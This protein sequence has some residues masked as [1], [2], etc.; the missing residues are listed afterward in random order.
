MAITRRK[1]FGPDQVVDLDKYKDRWTN[2]EIQ[3]H[4]KRGKFITYKF[5]DLTKYGGDIYHSDFDNIGIRYDGNRDNAH[6][7][8][9]KSYKRVGW[10]YS[11]FPPIV[12][13][14]DNIKDGRTRIKAAINAGET[15]IAVAVFDYPEENDEVTAYIHQLSEGLIG[16]DDLYTRPTNYKGIF[17]SGL[18]AVKKA[19]NSGI[20]MHNRTE[21]AKLVIEEFEAERFL[22]SEEI[23]QVIDDI[24]EAISNGQEAIWLPT[25]EEVLDYIGKSP[26][27]PQDACLEGDICLNGKRVFVYAAPSNTNQGRL[28]AKIAD[29]I[30]EECYIVLYTTK[31]IPSKIKKGYDD[32][33]QYVDYRY[34]ECFEIVNRTC[35]QNGSM[36]KIQAP[37]TRPWKVIGVIPQLAQDET[38][39]S[40]K[41]SFELIPLEEYC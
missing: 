19:E 27:L 32:F 11:S 16:N 37:K 41:K 26:N 14:K 3:S 2:E 40:K 39:L 24:N 13:I 33:M 4:V 1:G 5:L 20:N 10:Q 36:I 17:E 15:F 12:D 22:D 8:I 28:W 30:P 35:D 29:E 31:R 25:R 38:H 21:I 9:T 18:A 7:I 6:V 23:S 34:R